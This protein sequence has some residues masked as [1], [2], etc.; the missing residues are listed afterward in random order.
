MNLPGFHSLGS[1][2]LFALLI[3]LLILYFL[4][5]K[6]PRM[7]VPSLALWQQVLND[8][9]VNSPFQKFKRNIL[10]LLQFLMLSALCL[11]AMQPFVRGGPE[12]YENLPILID[13][14]ASMSA[15]D[16]PDGK[17]R[18]DV[19]KEQVEELI[20]GLGGDQRL[21]IV[22]VT[23][24][25]R[26]LTEFTNNKRILRNALS[27][28]EPADVPGALEDAMR[29]TLA[30]SRTETIES[31]VVLSDGNFPPRVDFELPFTLA[32]QQIPPG[33]SNLGIIEFNA[34]RSDKTTW[35]VFIRVGGTRGKTDEK[36]GADIALLQ[37]GTEIAGD[38]VVIEGGATQRLN[39]KVTAD[40]DSTLQAQL[41]PIG[42]DSME[43]DNFAWMELPEGR[44]LR[45]FAEGDMGPWRHAL[46]GL[47][48][49]ELYPKP[50]DD[51]EPAKYDVI[52]SDAEE[53]FER[54]GLVRT[55][56]GLIPPDLTSMLGESEGETQIVDWNRTEPLLQHVQ[57]ADIT[58]LD[59]PVRKEG[60][61]DNQ[62]EELGYE[63]LAWGDEGP[64]LLKRRDGVNL[65]FYFLFHTDSSTLPYR[66]AFPITV[67]NTINQG[68]RATALS[69][70][71]G[72][73]TGVLAAVPL[74]SETEYT[75]RGPG[76]SR[77]EI[78]S[79]EQ[80]ML[81]GVPA[82][83]VG[84]YEIADGGDTVRKV[85]AGLLSP[86]ESSLAGV[87]EIQFREVKVGAAETTVK[88]DRPLWKWLA[89]GAFALL[90]VEWW[91]FQRRP[92]A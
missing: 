2:W 63:I 87:E 44:P 36:L 49:I 64:L 52:I 43:C 9:R 3:P 86:M 66:L 60:V 62:I 73:R 4:K 8:Q 51:S 10:L 55:F 89:I 28:I 83:K 57:L 5:L 91:Y 35:D 42:F 11:A 72:Q 56:V 23:S 22:A 29:M 32:Y 30:M 17:S 78:K 18:L 81:S 13:C 37:N 65:A 75:V 6:R 41:K 7:E 14:S 39:F 77:R 31:V 92:V 74:V 79:D 53:D 68:L 69:E 45:V 85:G 84:E 40:A 19:A 27:K 58:V 21:C 38:T 70:V 48:D 80:G 20:D 76:G 50:G 34:R 67:A 1:A 90:L 61:V 16:Q 54:E 24:T 82:P 71:R 12:Q 59:P 26:R 15:L 46:G 47:K 33:G 25:G 88:N